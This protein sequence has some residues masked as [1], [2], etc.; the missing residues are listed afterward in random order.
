MDILHSRMLKS[1]DNLRENIQYSAKYQLVILNQ[2]QKYT[3][4]FP[5]AKKQEWP[6]KLKF[7][8]PNSKLNFAY[9]VQCIVYMG[10]EVLL[11]VLL[12]HS[13]HNGR[14]RKV[15]LTKVTT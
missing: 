1:D 11:I 5:L 9:T 2:R 13:S 8:R 4:K 12:L 15:K 3:P 6:S 7:L 10:R 14:N